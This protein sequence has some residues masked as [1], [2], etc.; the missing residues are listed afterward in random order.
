MTEFAA[1]ILRGINSVLGNY[2]WSIMVFTLMIRILLFP[3]DYKSRV[4]MRKTAKLQPKMEELRRKYS[5]DQAKLNQKM[6]DLYKQEKV[7][8]MSGCLPLLLSYPILIW[9]FAAMRAISN[10][11]VVQQVIAVLQNPNELPV[12]EGWLWVRNLWMPDSPFSSSLVDFNTLRTVTEDVWKRLIT[13]EVLATLPAELEL[14]LESFTKDNLQ[15]TLTAIWGVLEQTPVYVEHGGAVP[16]WTIPILITNISLMKEWNGLFLLPILSALTQLVM[17]N[18][19]PA[20]PTAPDGAQGPGAGTGKFMKYFFPIFSLWICS[21]YNAGFALYW[22]T[23]NLIAMATTFLI[24]KH[25]DR[26]EAAGG[27]T[28]A[29]EGSIK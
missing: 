15:A 18:L 28:I 2:G 20:A 1:N 22:V 9:M 4:S 17:S 12:F 5:K 16:G 21:S 11:A 19:T 24:N 6:S 25:L 14:T 23:A 10:E 7:S 3:F 8:P 13:P 29:A 26:K 27:G